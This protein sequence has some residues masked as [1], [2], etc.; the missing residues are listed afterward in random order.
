MNSTFEVSNTMAII[1]SIWQPSCCI[2]LPTFRKILMI[3]DNLHNNWHLQKYTTNCNNKVESCINDNSVLD[4]NALF[5]VHICGQFFMNAIILSHMIHVL[6]DL[7]N[8]FFIS[9]MP[10]NYHSTSYKV[11]LQIEHILSNS[12]FVQWNRHDDNHS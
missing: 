7:W 8:K 6:T 2:Q 3:P 10:I 11:Y 1:S 5:C 12:W 9:V 4:T